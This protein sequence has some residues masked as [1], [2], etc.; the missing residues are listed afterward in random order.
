MFRKIILV[1]VA[2][3]FCTLSTLAIAAHESSCAPR[4]EI[5]GHLADKYSEAPVAI[6]LAKNGGVIE[7]LTSKSGKT[8]TI[9]VTMPN[10]VTCM[11]A[12]GEGWESLST[13][14]TGLAI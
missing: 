2:L 12:A 4:N 14:E 8:W 3:V 5:L 9:I 10:G 1:G 7:V 13:E 6:G 11:L